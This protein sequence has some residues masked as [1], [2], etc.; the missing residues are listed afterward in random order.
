[1]VLVC[2][3]SH[4]MTLSFDCIHSYFVFCYEFIHRIQILK[5]LFLSLI[6]EPLSIS[7]I[8]AASDHGAKVRISY[9]VCS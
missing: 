1:M 8:V 6:V 7:D 9:K 5:L 4:L 3:L 2:L